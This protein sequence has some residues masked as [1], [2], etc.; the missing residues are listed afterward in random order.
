M[1]TLIN[2]RT[3]ESPHDTEL[4]KSDLVFQQLADSGVC[5]LEQRDERTRL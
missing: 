4:I 1:L 2:I 3:N 5:V